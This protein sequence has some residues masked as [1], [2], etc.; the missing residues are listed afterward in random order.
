MYAVALISHLP[1]IYSTTTTNLGSKINDSCI[2]HCS[3]GRNSALLHV[4]GYWQTEEYKEKP[5]KGLDRVV[6]F[7]KI[8]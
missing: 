7:N 5:A 6:G 4:S 2:L 8:I 3:L 1:P